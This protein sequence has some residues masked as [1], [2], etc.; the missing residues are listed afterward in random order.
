MRECLVIGLGYLLAFYVGSFS[1][2]KVV[3]KYGIVLE[4]ILNTNKLN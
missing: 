3:N 2:Y 4:K 1:V